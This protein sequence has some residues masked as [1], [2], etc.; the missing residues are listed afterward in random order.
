MRSENPEKTIFK[1]PHNWVENALNELEPSLRSFA[2]TKDLATLL[3]LTRTQIWNEMKND[4][5]VIL[6]RK[7]WGIKIDENEIAIFDVTP[8][9]GYQEALA[10]ESKA[11]MEAKARKARAKVEAAGRAAEIMG[12]VI[13]SLVESTGMSKKK[14]QEEFQKDPK[15]FYEE[16][17]TIID[18]VVTKLSMEERSYLRIETPGAEGV[19]GDF[20]RLIAAWQRIPPGTPSE[21]KPPEKKEPPLLEEKKPRE[22]KKVEEMTLEELEEGAE[23][24]FEE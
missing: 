15:A 8:P 19:L 12:T 23:E 10:A 1:A 4:H 16:H 2:R 6:L 18:S 14:I 20:L 11:K 22:K 21:K 3:N 9:P 7:E 13:Q 24:F 17:K 5:A